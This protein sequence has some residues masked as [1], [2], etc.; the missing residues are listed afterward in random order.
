MEADPVISEIVALPFVS[1]VGTLPHPTAYVY[2][3]NFKDG[4]RGSVAFDC[5]QIETGQ[6]LLDEMMSMAR[7]Q[8]TK[9]WEEHS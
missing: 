1:K 8:F 9:L 4:R 7:E 2:W 3:A 5:G 6:V